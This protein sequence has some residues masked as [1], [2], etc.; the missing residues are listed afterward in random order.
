[1]RVAMFVLFICAAFRT[2][3]SRLTGFDTASTLICRSLPVEGY[4]LEGE[5]ALK[6]YQDSS[7]ETV[8]N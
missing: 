4:V 1:M 6:A 3:C 2:A 8:A 5:P 7:S